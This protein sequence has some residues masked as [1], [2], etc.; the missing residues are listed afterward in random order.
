[1]D[2]LCI[3][4]SS[5][6]ILF[7]F[8]SQEHLLEVIQHISESSPVTVI[9][10]AMWGDELGCVFVL[11]VH[12]N[13]RHVIDSHTA[14]QS[15]VTQKPQLSIQSISSELYASPTVIADENFQ[16][17]L[18]IELTTTNLSPRRAAP[19]SFIAAHSR[20]AHFF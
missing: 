15:C 17:P 18:Y 3:A 14:I 11:Q 16:L 6:C 20:L 5:L 2:A 4:D 13:V 10:E 1:L 19:A 12:Q 9:G 7:H 8:V